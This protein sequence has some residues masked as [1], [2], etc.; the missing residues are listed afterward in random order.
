[1]ES[2]FLYLGKVSIL[3]TVFYLAY[4]FLLKKETFFSANRWYLILG[5]FTSVLL[6]LYTYTKII[7]VNPQP[8]KTK[9]YDTFH[10]SAVQE[11]TTVDWSHIITY[12]YGLISLFLFL[13]V[14]FNLASLIRLL[15]QKEK[16][17]KESYSLVNLTENIAPFSFFNYIAINPDLYTTE[18]LEGILLHEKVH[19]RE[20]HSFDVLIA[21]LFCVL[22]WFNPFVWLY[23][24]VIIQNL[25]FIAD[26][27]AIQCYSDK[28]DY[29]KALLRVVTHQ[30]Y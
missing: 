12:L 26:Q 2:F 11:I 19:S 6:P 7:Y 22:F 27:K 29:Q 23:K 14:I 1:M 8:Q 20:K 9:E 28:T 18:E 15:S 17:K 24:K 30:S 5:L 16:Y 13:K 25:E 4:Y 3:L 10:P 21:N